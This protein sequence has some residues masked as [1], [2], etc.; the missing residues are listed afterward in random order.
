MKK[1]RICR[2]VYFGV[3]LYNKVK[4]KRNDKYLDLARELKKKLRNMGVTLILI[5]IGA[6]GTVPK[7]LEKRLRGIGN[8]RKNQYHPDYS[9]AEI[10]QNTEKCPGNLRKLAVTPR[11]DR[12]LT[13]V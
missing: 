4:K 2:L 10:G 3:P 1:R 5:I 13:L 12:Q 6:L 11:K 8:Q 9:I 7:G